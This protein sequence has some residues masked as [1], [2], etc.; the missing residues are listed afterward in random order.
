MGEEL[1]GFDVCVMEGKR[2]EGEDVEFDEV[3]I[4][5]GIEASF[6]LCWRLLSGNNNGTITV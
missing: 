2:A 5:H 4:E 1:T 6:G 3:V